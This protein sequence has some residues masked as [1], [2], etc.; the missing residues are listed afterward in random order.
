MSSESGS[1]I[2]VSHL[3]KVYHLYPT[4]QDR[5]K[6][7]IMPRFQR[8]L[9]RPVKQ[10]YTEHEALRD[11]SFSVGKG[12]TLGIIGR[13]GAGKSTLLQII[14]GT[15]Q[16]TSG[17]VEINGRIAALLE[18]G[19]G[20]NTEFTGRENVFIYGAILGLGHQEIAARFDEIA[21]F[22]AIGEFIDQPVKTYSSGMY[23]RLAFAV[24]VCLDPEILV[25]DEALAVGDVKFQAKCFRRFE[26]LV[27]RGTTIL[28]VTHSTEQ[29]VRHCDRAILLHEGGIACE[30]EPRTVSN[31]YLDLM[32]GVQRKESPEAPAAQTTD[33]RSGHDLLSGRF[34]DRPGYNENEYRWGNRLAEI[35]DFHISQDGVTHETSLV[36]EKPFVVLVAVDFKE[37]FENPIYGL[38]V[39][40][41]DGMTVYSCNSRDQRKGALCSVVNAGDEK[42]IKYTVGNFLGTGEFLISL[43]VAVD[44]G[45]EIVPLDRR[46]DSIHITIAN[47]TRMG[48]VVDLRLE[49]EEL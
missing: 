11:I 20:F 17:Q 18:L 7:M 24:S 42:I 5:I 37:H 41:P 27:S 35:R 1:T 43:G 40:T 38:T 12:E 39:K 25:V 46:F 34:S 16:A 13:N 2:R 32:F 30:G 15:L 44:Q 9:R 28:F 10:Y 48:G 14:C 26:E 45:G 8:W 33:A 36:S 29:I 4:P 19:A 47:A 22:A 3:A 6:Q 31:Y 49:V 23:V 21:D